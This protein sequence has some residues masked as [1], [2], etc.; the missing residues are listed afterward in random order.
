[1][2]AKTFILAEIRNGAYPSEARLA[3]IERY[4]TSPS[5][6]TIRRWAAD[7]G[8]SGLANN[9]RKASNLELFDDWLCVRF[10]RLV[11]HMEVTQ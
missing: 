3:S 8:M 4:G 11:K 1:M 5:A 7:A 9:K 10:N 2:D 6:N